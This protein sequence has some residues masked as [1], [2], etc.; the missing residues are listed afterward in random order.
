[1]FESSKGRIVFA[2]DFTAYT[3]MQNA[4]LAGCGRLD[5]TWPEPGAAA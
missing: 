1:M 3:R 2:G 5:L 4:D